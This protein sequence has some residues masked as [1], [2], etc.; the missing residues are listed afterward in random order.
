[1]VDQ[2]DVRIRRRDGAPL[3]LTR[4]DRAS[5]SSEGAVTAARALRNVL[6]HMSPEALIEALRDE[7]PWADLLPVES[8]SEFAADFAHAFRV[9]AELGY[10]APLNQSMH[11][12]K[13]TAAVYADP[14][15]ADHLSGPVEGDL[16]P[17]PPPTDSGT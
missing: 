15:L 8:R 11:E 7:F 6:H 4:E 2:G 13:A 9:S 5:E 3:M 14:A 16:G 17:V 12:W 1:M 10:W